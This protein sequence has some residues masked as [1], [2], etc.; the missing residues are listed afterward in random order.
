MGPQWTQ[1][2]PLAAIFGFFLP[3]RL[4]QYC[5]VLPHQ[6]LGDAALVNR[7]TFMAGGAALAGLAAGIAHGATVAASGAACVHCGPMARGTACGATAARPQYAGTKSA[8]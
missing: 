4:L 7:A 3:L 8:A 5:L 1:A 2:A 6:G